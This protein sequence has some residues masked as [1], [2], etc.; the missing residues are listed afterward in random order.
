M[1][2]PVV[3]GR[4]WG[5]FVK[6]CENEKATVKVIKIEPGQQLSVKTHEHR[7]EM[8]VA[9]DQGLVAL[10]GDKTIFMKDIVIGE[11][12]VWVPRGVP[13]SIKNVNVGLDARFLE[14][15]FGDFDENDIKRIKDRY[16]RT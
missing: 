15:S 2:I 11:D 7:D 16:G 1:R 8:W 5:E 14:I 6:F 10:V 13:H 9:L 3:D 12:P 4:P